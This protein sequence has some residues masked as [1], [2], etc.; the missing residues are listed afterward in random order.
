MILQSL[1]NKYL[2][3]HNRYQLLKRRVRV[4]LQYILLSEQDYCKLLQENPLM[5]ISVYKCYYTSILNNNSSNDN[6][7]NSKDL[8]SNLIINHEL[9][10]MAVHYCSKA[11]MYY[12]CVFT[13]NE[14]LEESRATSYWSFNILHYFYNNGNNNDEYLIELADNYAIT[15]WRVKTLSIIR[16]DVFYSHNKLINNSFFQEYL[17]KPVQIQCEAILCLNHL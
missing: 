9:L 3:E 4:H 14:F 10:Y 12:Y 1:L 5:P 6:A 13:N 17:P 16:Q 2:V 15:Y 7:S 8:I 11:Q